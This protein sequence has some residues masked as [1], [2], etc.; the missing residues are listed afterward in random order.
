MRT[1]LVPGLIKN[2][3]LNLNHQEQDIRLFEIG[4]AY[5]PIENSELPNEITKIA[6]TATWKRTPEFWGREEFDFFDFKSILE[7]GF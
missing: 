2:S 3:I 7:K 6:A 1:S 4:K 5:L